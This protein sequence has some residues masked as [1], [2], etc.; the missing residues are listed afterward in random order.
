M[1]NHQ[2]RNKP[3]AA[4]AVLTLALSGGLAQ[5]GELPLHHVTLRVPPLS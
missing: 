4:T 3:M 5:A 1:T 2:T